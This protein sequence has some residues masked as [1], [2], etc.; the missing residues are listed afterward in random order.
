MLPPS[1]E[2]LDDAR[3]PRPVR[4]GVAGQTYWDTHFGVDHQHSRP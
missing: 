1:F 2:A 3:V 4:Y